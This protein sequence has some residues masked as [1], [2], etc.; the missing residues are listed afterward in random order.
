M[1]NTTADRIHIADL[2]KN[3]IN[4]KMKAIKHKQEMFQLLKQKSSRSI[5]PSLKRARG[6]RQSRR[7]RQ[8]KLRKQHSRG[9]IK[10]KSHKKRHY[11]SKRHNKSKRRRR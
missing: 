11:K 5:Y 4:D 1:Y 7:R 10:A 8:S 2:A 9:H 3:K 6:V